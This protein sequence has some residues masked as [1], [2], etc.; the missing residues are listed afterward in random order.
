MSGYETYLE[1][2]NDEAL[3]KG[4]PNDQCQC[5]HWGYLLAGRMT[6]T[7]S[8]HQDVVEASEAYYMAP[9]HTMAV[10]AGTVL[11]E[12]SP[13]DKFQELMEFAEQKMARMKNEQDD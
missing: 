11:I 2:F 12:F 5:P 8:D 1:D 4:L 6:V 10:E 9:G 13:K 3:L 7:Y